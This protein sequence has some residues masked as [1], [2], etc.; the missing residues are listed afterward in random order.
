ML[1]FTASSYR[2]ADS[3]FDVVFT[4][5]EG[6]LLGEAEGKDN[7]PINIDK[8]RQ[9]SMN[10]HEDLSRDE[11]SSPAK[12]V[13]FGNGYRLSDPKD[14]ELQFTDK[15]LISSKGSS[16]ALVTTSSLYTVSKFLTDQ[17]DDFYARK[18]RQAILTGI[19]VVVFPPL[20]ENGADNE[21]I[22][23]VSEASC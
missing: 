23:E 14:R 11:V 16:I 19:G 8:L 4:C 15:C 3:E 12:G 1:G 5:D 18:C 2:D 22:P 9:L 7:K 17:R 10:I 21:S 13:L 20:P 6:R